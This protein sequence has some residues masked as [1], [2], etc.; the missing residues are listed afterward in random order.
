MTVEPVLRIRDATLRFGD[1]TLWSGLD[2]DVAPGEFIT[3]LGS[4]GS[5]K[6]SLLKAILGLQRLSAGSIEVLGTPVGRGDQSI[7]YVP[8][9][10]LIPAGTPL[11]GRD[12]VSLGVDGHRLGVRLRGRRETA[13]RV[14]AAIA[15][16]R[17]EDFADQPVGQL[18][19]GEQQRLR[20]AQALVAEPALLLCDEPLISLDLHHQ[21]AVSDLVDARRRT[22]R[23]P[24]LFITHDINPVLPL[25]D[26]VLYFAGGRHRLGTPEEV[27]RSEVLSELYDTTVEVAEFGGRIVVLGAP[28]QHDHHTEAH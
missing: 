25:T 16:V 18:S 14:G 17:A 26:R 21:R 2:L 28:D 9:Q 27:M 20:I 5:G 3:V 4:N 15:A 8:Q 24:V 1:R 23:T 6:S 12:L 19:G 13:V 7:G 11:R 10:R 22:A